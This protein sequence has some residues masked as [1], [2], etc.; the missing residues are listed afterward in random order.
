MSTKLAIVLAAAVSLV[1][2][3]LAGNL[4]LRPGPRPS[5]M[6]ESDPA[7]RHMLAMLDDKC[8]QC[9]S[10]RAT[11][12][13]Y[14]GLPGVAPLIAADKARARRAFDLDAELP[15]S[16]SGPVPKA[17]LAKLQLAALGERMPPLRYR[18]LHLNA[19][20]NRAEAND[21]VQWAAY[22]RE[23]QPALVR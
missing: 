6:A 19:M 15:P 5:T 12:P 9:H 18:A 4:I 22:E 3:I 2:L 14:G 11:L 8:Q 7:Y 20:L 23:R 16:S 1:V 10:S 13:F 17:T 21:L